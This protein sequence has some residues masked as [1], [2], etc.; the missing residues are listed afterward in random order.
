MGFLGLTGFGGGATSLVNK[1]SAAGGM[2]FY[3]WGAGGGD[4]YLSL[5][6]I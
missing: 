3:M 4:R 2:T 1:T 6:H 5:I